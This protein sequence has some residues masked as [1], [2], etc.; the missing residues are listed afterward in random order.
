MPTEVPQDIIFVFDSSGSLG[1]SGYAQQIAYM[2]NIVQTYGDDALHPTRFG[3]VEFSTGAIEH[4]SFFD[5][6]DPTQI[7]N[8]LDTLN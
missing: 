2:K 4:Y 7:L 6:Q 1:S 8:Y 3:L 5:D